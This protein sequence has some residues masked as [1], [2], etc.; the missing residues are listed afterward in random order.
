MILNEYRT[1]FGDKIFQNYI[2]IL[3]AQLCE[4]TK[5]HDRY[6]LKD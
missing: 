5:T 3:V 1:S 6:T 4:Y 2:V